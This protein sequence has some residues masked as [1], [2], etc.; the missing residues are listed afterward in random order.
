MNKIVIW[1]AVVPVVLL[2]FVLFTSSSSEDV[3]VADEGNTE[4]QAEDALVLEDAEM[5]LKSA[6]DNVTDKEWQASLN[7]LVTALKPWL[8]E[9]RPQHYKGKGLKFYMAH[10]LDTYWLQLGDEVQNPYGEGHP[11]VIEWPDKVDAEIP[12]TTE[13]PAGGAHANH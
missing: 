7:K 13:M 8:L 12:E 10:G 2:G 6:Q 1:A 3:D 4:E 9:G 11:T 5:A